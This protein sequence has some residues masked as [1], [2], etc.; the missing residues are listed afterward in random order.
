[1]T[2]VLNVRKDSVIS[3]KNNGWHVDEY[4]SSVAY[5]IGYDDPNL[6]EVY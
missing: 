4:V 5:F 3:S 6:W 2:D 1:M